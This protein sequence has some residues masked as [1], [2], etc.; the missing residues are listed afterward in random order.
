M[1]RALIFVT[2]EHLDDYCPRCADYLNRCGMELTAVVIDDGDGRRWPE[3]ATL[4]ANGE[5]DVVVVATRA[6]LPPD[7]LPRID[8]VAE[9][10]RRM[11]PDQRC[12]PRLLR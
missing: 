9:R 11:I 12:R 4:L 3:V 5:V 2:R 10:S 8:V 7:R 1:L 6:E